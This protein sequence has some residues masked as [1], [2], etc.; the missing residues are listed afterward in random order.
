MNNYNLTNIFDQ[1]KMANLN[2]LANNL[3]QSNSYNAPNRFYSKVFD[4]LIYG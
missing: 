1:I 4:I 2:N 3:I